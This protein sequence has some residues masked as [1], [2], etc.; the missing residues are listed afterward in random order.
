MEDLKLEQDLETPDNSA[1]EALHC[2]AL[3]KQLQSEHKFR[4]AEKQYRRAI[5]QNPNLWEAYQSLADLLAIKNR[6]RAIL[7]VYRQGIKNN[8]Q[9]P[10][11]LFTLA[12]ALAAQ[13]KWRNASLRYQQALKLKTEAPWG[14]FNWAKVLVE[15][16]EWDKAQ[17]ATIKALQLK[18][19]L[20]EAYHHLGK[21]LQHRHQWQSAITAYHKVIQLNPQFVHAYM[22]LAEVYRHLKQE[23]FTLDCYSYVIQNAVEKSPVQQQAFACYAATLEELPNPTAEQ[24]CELAT[25]YRAQSYFSEAIAAYQQAIELDPQFVRAYIMIQYTP[26]ETQQLSQLVDFYRQL[27]AQHDNIPLAWGNLGDALSEQNK[28]SEAIDCYRTSCYQR[29]TNFYPRLADL[30]WQKPKQ[31]TPDFI[32]VGSS[33]CGTSSL[34][35]YLSRH[36][37][38][39]LSHKK[40]I[41]FFWQYFDKGIDWYLAHFPTIT[42]RSDLISGEA[43]PNYLRFPL[44]AKRIKEICPDTKLIVLLR[45]PVERAISWHYHKVNSGLATGSLANALERE[46]AELKTFNEAQF[47]QGGYRKIDNIFSSLYYYQFKVWLD[48]LP[49]EQ[50]LILKSEDFY[51]NTASVMETVFDFLNVPPQELAQYQKI[52]AGSYKSQAVDA[53]IRETLTTY[54]EP[55]NQKLEEL[56]DLKFNW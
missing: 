3:G 41:D 20:W 51:S 53:A 44:V 37:Q 15:L 14:Y 9:N 30:D 56:L 40:E 25:M 29:V 19:D 34:Y 31:N 5:S 52:N 42:D 27:V 47:L 55:Y 7:A 48:Y 17:A 46:I 18:S 24:Y 10:R 35:N 32:I 13:K 6:N 54:F 50:F 22:R 21:I 4:Q 16:K 39:L 23:K 26:I 12:Q 1:G 28:I 8:P 45:N 11:Y 43:T 38:I 36:P 49:R 33:K 2:V